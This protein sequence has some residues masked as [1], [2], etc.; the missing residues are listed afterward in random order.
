MKEHVVS[1][2]KCVASSR[3]INCT[4]EDSLLMEF[5]AMRC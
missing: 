2:I 3:L 4:C 1:G 5:F